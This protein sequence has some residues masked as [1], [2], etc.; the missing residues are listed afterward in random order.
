[1][2][3]IKQYTNTSDQELSNQLKVFESEFS[4]PLNNGTFSL[5]HGREGNYF[6]FFHSLGNFFTLIISDNDQIIGCITAIEK[7][8]NDE[9]YLYFCDLKFK[10]L[11]FDKIVMCRQLL[12]NTLQSLKD[13]YPQKYLFVNMNPKEKNT[14]VFLLS[15]LL[16]IKFITSDLYI[17]E[18]NIED[19]SVKDNLYITNDG[20]KDMIINDSPI[21]LYHLTSIKNTL[22]SPTQN[23]VFMNTSMSPLSRK[24]TKATLAYYGFKNIPWI[25]SYQ[26]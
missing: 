11:P 2:I 3:D 20:K 5:C 23:T 7:T 9:K 21:S 1:M 4:Y 10:K 17:N 12:K 14:V 22:P 25:E 8:I 15:K 26:I 19:I 24:Y 6:D 13:K 16:N 18:Y